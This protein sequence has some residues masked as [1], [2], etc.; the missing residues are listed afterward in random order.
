VGHTVLVMVC[1]L[2]FNLHWCL[3]TRS[4]T[5][6]VC[7]I[8]LECTATRSSCSVCTTNSASWGHGF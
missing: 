8:A 3:M 5:F 2:V 4:R 6:Y 1:L 7:S